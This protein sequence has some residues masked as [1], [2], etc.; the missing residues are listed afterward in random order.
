MPSERELLQ[1]LHGIRGRLNA[2]LSLASLEARAGWSR[3]HLH[4]AFRRIVGETP[5]QYTL[6]LRL[7]RAAGRLIA[8]DERV[9]AIALDA[10]FASHEVFTRAFNRQFGQ[11]PA[12]YRRMP[13]RRAPA[14]VRARHA[15][16]AASTGACV[17]LFHLHV[18]PRSGRLTMP[19]LTIERRT[20][21]AQP[22]LFIR[23]RIARD[24]LAATLGQC[25]GAVFGHCQKAGLALDG[26]P[27]TRYLSAG[28]G[29]WT[30]EAGTPLALAAPGE[31]DIEAGML[32]A[33]A[34]AVAVHA[35][36]YEQLQE[37]Y[38]AMERWIESSGFR[39]SGAPWES[40]VTDPAD[41]PDPADW[42]T[43]VYWPLEQ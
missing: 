11:S 28:P 17:G 25:F 16:V 42:R 12:G 35:G 41:H 43:E 4:R 7:E 30:I 29:L 22:V 13:L 26:R 6:R 5:K 32:P 33:G 9:T 21:A 27:Y 20:L 39:T 1:L 37:T 15:E 23:R 2:N 40:Y 3:F 38:A 14:D 24:E 8:T 34:T 36:P 18:T 31:G 19:T 10:G